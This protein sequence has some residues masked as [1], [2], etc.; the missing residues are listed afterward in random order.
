VSSSSLLP[1]PVLLIVVWSQ[2]G[3]TTRFANPED[4]TTQQTDPYPGKHNLVP[5]SVQKQVLGDHKSQ[6]CQVEVV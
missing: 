2:A 4:R 5:P 3:H 6:K 1:A